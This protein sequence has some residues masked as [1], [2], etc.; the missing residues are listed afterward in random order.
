MSEHIRYHDFSFAEVAEAVHIP[1]TQ[2]GAQQCRSVLNFLEL[3]LF[4][5]EFD[6]ILFKVREYCS[7]AFFGAPRAADKV[8]GVDLKDVRDIEGFRC[9]NELI[10]SVLQIR[11]GSD[12]LQLAKKNSPTA[13]QT[14][15]WSKIV[16]RVMAERIK[17]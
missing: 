6:V 4:Y 10:Y 14:M 13:K 8:I 12:R 7:Y 3:A 11:G 1:E 2:S 17:A 9:M 15:V 16:L 5:L